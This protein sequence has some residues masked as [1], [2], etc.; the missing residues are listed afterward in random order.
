M[1]RRP[2]LILAF[3]LSLAFYSYAE[4]V[5]VTDKSKNFVDTNNKEAVLVWQSPWLTVPAASF[6]AG[7][8]PL[9]LDVA[10]RQNRVI[11]EDVQM[12]R[13]NTFDFRP[14]HFDNYTQYL[15]ML[16]VH[17][18]DWSGVPSRHSGWTLARRS[19][20][21]IAISSAIVHTIKFFVDEQRPD[22]SSLTSFPSGHTAFSFAG[23]E[24]L[25]LEY[26]HVSPLIPVAG[27]VVASLTGFM[28]IY[29]DK[30]WCGDVLAG[31]ALGIVCADFSYWIND[32][33]DPLFCSKQHR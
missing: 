6:T 19:L 10:Y 13:R 28:R 25:R 7:T 12:M 17:I 26:G 27:Y 3:M 9:W 18:L 16:T 5:V 21:A 4:G 8:T 32:L 24:M 1:A 20:G 15:P 2:F 22:R 31:M 14:L 11:R 30:H 23:A 29:N 33:L